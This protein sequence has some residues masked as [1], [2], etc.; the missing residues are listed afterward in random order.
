MDGG[1]TQVEVREGLME[2]IRSVVRE[3]VAPRAADIDRV[4][5]FPQDIRRL[6]SDLG[7]L[8]LSVPE[9][10][11]GFGADMETTLDVV[12]EIAATCANSANIVTQQALGIAPIL[13]GGSDEQKRRW[14]PALAAGE[15][16]ASF[17]LTEPGAG[18]DNRSMRTTFQPVDG[19]F[20]LTG[21]KVFITWGNIAQVMTVFGRL[22]SPTDGAFLAGVIELPADGFVV[23]RLEEK[24]GMHGS[25][26]T[27]VTFDS[28]FV[29]AENVL[30]Q[31][32]EGL[33]IA[34]ASLDSGRVEIGAL[35]LGIGRGA[36]VA[37]GRYLRQREQFGRPLSE[38]QGLRFKIADHA[39]RLEA[40]FQ[41]LRAAAKAIDSGS[42]DATR[43]AAMAKLFATDAGME[44]ATDAVGLLGGYGY[45]RDYPLERMMRDAKAMQIVEGTNEIQRV[46]IAREWFER[47]A[48]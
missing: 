12:L 24:M 37:A 39:T 9:E 29:S 36:L 25:P 18:S 42:S 40:G 26:T 20:R 23:N 44:A 3:R 45:L 28:V 2:T 7:L 32:G 35:G 30:G 14:L 8:G 47:L 34:L 10:Y 33:R 21:S 16:L 13:Y 22:G 4:G 1:M 43:L 5:E 41:L 31:P 48:Q 38:Y 19:G 17:A 6:F 15:T 27:Q 11:G 46:V